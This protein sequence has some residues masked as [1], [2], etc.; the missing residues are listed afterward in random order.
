MK[1]TYLTGSP[2]SACLSLPPKKKKKGKSFFSFLSMGKNWSFT[3]QCADFVFYYGGKAGGVSAFH[4]INND[5]IWNVCYSSLQTV[6][7]AFIYPLL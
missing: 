6:H 1:I 4:V 5:A 2:Q 7:G 3:L